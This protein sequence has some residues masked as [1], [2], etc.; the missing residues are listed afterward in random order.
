MLSVSNV[1]A[2]FGE[3]QVKHLTGL[4]VGRLRYWHKTGFFAPTFVEENVRIPYS[5]F[6]SFK[7]MVALRT[8]EP[9]HVQNGVPLQQ[10]RKVAEK[11]S[12]LK[13]DL[14][15]NTTL[16]VVNK[17]VVLENPETGK[18]EEVVSG[19]YLLGIPLK[20]VVSDTSADVE[21]MRKRSPAQIGTISKF[22]GI[23][24][25]AWVI[26]GTRIPIASI[27]RMRE[28]GL[29]DDQIISEYPDLTQGDISAALLHG[30]AKAA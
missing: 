30:A 1:V 7:D 6:Y 29:T 26:A 22:S 12:H 18:P 27:R 21:V 25:N 16:Y 24:H 4:G 15:T 11:L 17:K 9:L 14:W 20:K 19:Q 2:A 13:D 8:L 10:L 23:C 5:R 28:D 3:E